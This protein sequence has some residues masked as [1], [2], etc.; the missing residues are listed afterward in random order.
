VDHQLQQLFDFGL[1][2]QRFAAGGGALGH[3]YLLEKIGFS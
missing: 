3:V 2:S 1:E